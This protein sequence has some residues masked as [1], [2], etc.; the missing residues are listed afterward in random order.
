MTAEPTEVR[1]RMYNV[2][3]GDCFLLT[4]AYSDDDRRHVLI[5]FGTMGLPKR[6]G[7]RLHTMAKIAEQIADDAGGKLTAVVAT[8]RHQDHISGFGGSTGV[9]IEGLNPEFVLQPWTE[10]PCIPEHAKAPA[11]HRTAKRFAAMTTELEAVLADQGLLFVPGETAVDTFLDDDFDLDQLTRPLARYKAAAPG[12]ADN[13]L[14][15]I[16]FLGNNNIKNDNAVRRL[17]R[18]GREGKGLYLEAGDEPTA[19]HEALPGVRIHVLGPPSADESGIEVQADADKTEFWH[20]ARNA[21]GV[22]LQGLAHGADEPMRFEPRGGIPVECRWLAEHIAHA[23][24]RDLLAIVRDLDHAL[25]NTSLVLLLEVWSSA[26]RQ[27]LLFPGDAQIENWRHCLADGKYDELLADVDVYK[28]G[29]HGSLNAT[30]RLSLWPKFRKRGTGETRRLVTLL[31]TQTGRHG[32]QRNKTE[33]PRG[34]LV[35]A[36]RNESMLKDTRRLARRTK[37]TM[38]YDHVLRR[39]SG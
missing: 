24:P 20:L 1:I 3:F 37:N 14:K 33:V 38:Y 35:T 34:P 39:S 32:H 8:H 28:V 19:L 16:V 22:G 4:F 9:T 11:G 27:I 25:N 5:D 2:G 13:D 7:Q 15:D 21:W 17:M 10:D 30:P 18:M 36:L 31:S 26:D 23:R 29:H 12:M 6:N